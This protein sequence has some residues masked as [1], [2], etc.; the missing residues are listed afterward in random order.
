MKIKK[1]C[2]LQNGLA[3]GGTDTFV[4][5]LCKGLDKEKFDIILVNP[6]NKPGS[7]VRE[8]DVLSSGC[9]ILRTSPLNIGII[10]KIK[11]FKRL[12]CIL[13]KEQIDVFQSNIDLFNGPN[14][15]VSWL[16]RVP[17]RV[18]HSHNS[19]QNK[20]L[21]EGRTLAVRIYQF[22]MRWMCW[23]F[24]NRRTG[25]SPEAMDFLF[26]GHDW[27]NDS[28][29]TVVYNGIDV[30]RF[31]QTIDISNKRS[32]LGLSAKYNVLTVGR[33]IA[34]KNPFFIIDVFSELRNIR[35][36]VNFVWVGTGSM[37]NEVK[38]YIEEKKLSSC[39]QLL[40]ERNDI[41]DI[42]KCCDA[43]LMPSVFEGL[44]IVLIEAQAAGMTCLVSNEI[45]ELANCGACKKMSLLSASKEWSVALEDIIEK[46][47]SL[48]VD[49][50]RLKN[51]SIE[52][53]INQM[54]KVFNS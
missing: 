47:L 3:R 24:S 30:E 9:R 35:D 41:P 39:M 29:S 53:M 17:I 14:M 2:I 46:R 18:C 49:N 40:G 10:S 16:A 1:V 23:S 42:M 45:P 11:H 54:T 34:Q 4:V 21:V 27:R 37:E 25:C 12:Y 31:R 32:E 6:S 13:R 22:I 33:M 38:K 48:I 50:E 7:M 26:K 28:N 43:F 51:F 52:N 36:D 5:N 8:Q 44:G 20:E 15:L 19:L